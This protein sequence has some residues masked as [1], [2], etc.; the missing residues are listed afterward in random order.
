[1]WAGLL[2]A[3]LPGLPGVT[4]QNRG[5]VLA[6]PVAWASMLPMSAGV[7]MGVLAWKR[8]ESGIGSRESGGETSDARD[9]DGVAWMLAWAWVVSVG[10]LVVAGVS[11]HRY[12]L[13]SAVVLG[14]L[15]AWT[16]GAWTRRYDARRFNV[17]G[18]ACA[19][20]GVLLATG[21]AL[22][23]K[24]MWPTKDQMAGV[25]LAA[26]LV[27]AAPVGV[28]VWADDA[29][30]ARP[31]VLWMLEQRATGLRRGLS[32]VW[33]KREMSAGGL[34]RR[35]DCVLL[36]TDVGSG[37]AERYKEEIVSGRL[38]RVSGDKV[39]GYE[40]TLFRVAR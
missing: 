31:D 14:P 3:V 25:E 13:A 22:A 8:R 5:V 26:R 32:V 28:Q 23:A 19:A 38:E 18:V 34:P 4:G 10:V 20:G 6:V 36:R 30:E 40:F 16:L 35:G 27:E 7:V 17:A 33:A 2:A 21:A 1:M 39:R 24:S 37:E 12:A 15:M 11:N 9:G 29:I